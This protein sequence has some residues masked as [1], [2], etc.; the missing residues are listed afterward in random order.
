V[1]V[2][3]ESP[4]RGARALVV[5]KAPLP[6][7]TKTRLAARLGVDRAAELS[8]AMLLD[9]LDGCR[10]EVEEVGVLFASDDERDVLAALV[11]PHDVLLRQEGS[12][13][14]D[15]LSTGMRETL[16]RREISLLVSS[17]LPGVPPGS[18]RTACA[19]LRAGAEVVLGPGRDGGYWLVGMRRA[20]DEPFTDVPWSTSAVLETTL[21]RCRA[22]GLE[23]ELLEPW[24]DVDTADDLAALAALDDL[25]GRRT[26][27]LVAQLGLER[28]E[29]V[30]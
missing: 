23:V 15:A 9:T 5:A 2:S 10:E 3:V 18:L 30:S 11:E 21:D 17:D 13:L 26:R 8:R 27:A 25:P 7:R 20:S 1:S 14:G 22:A 24:R 4:G 29:S 19:A 28:A 12:G 16:S 6:G